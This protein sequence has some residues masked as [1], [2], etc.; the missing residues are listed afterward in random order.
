MTQALAITQRTLRATLRLRRLLLLLAFGLVPA[1]IY[2]L[3]ANQLTERRAL[4]LGVDLSL[5][6]YI[7][8]WVPI[9]TVILSSSALGDERRD[10]T[11]SFLVLRPIP[12]SLIAA[13][14]VAAAAISAVLVNLVGAIAIAAAYFLIAGSW[15]LLVPLLVGGA[16]ASLGY[17]AI[18][19]P[20]GYLTQ[21]AV[22]IG[23][24]LVVIFENGIVRA[25]S[26]LATLSPWRIGVSAFAALLPSEVGY[27]AADLGMGS[28][29]PGLWGALAKTVVLP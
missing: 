28:V 15:T 6:L 10:R 26:G 22:I 7:A 5:A 1:L 29:A 14:K 2:L 27:D 25:L 20:L 19:V 24:V 9:V 18:F 11:L 8:L 13:S 17:V 4:E 21:W 16:I 3:A 23:L 12:R